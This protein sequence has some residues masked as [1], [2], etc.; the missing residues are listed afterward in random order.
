LTGST[1]WTPIDL[2]A[3]EIE[4]RL[5]WL[6]RKR[7]EQRSWLR[8]TDPWEQRSGSA[9]HQQ[10]LVTHGVDIEGSML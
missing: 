5:A 6:Q 1:Q 10:A 7:R 3:E 2:P 9:L 4:R 8:I